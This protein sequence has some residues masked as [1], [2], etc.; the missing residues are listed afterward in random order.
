[1]DAKLQ[2]K[3]QINDLFRQ[4]EAK[5]RR[6]LRRHKGKTI[7]NRF[8]LTDVVQEVNTQ[9]LVAAETDTSISHFLDTAWL[10]KVASGHFCKLQRLH[11]AQ[12]RSVAKEEHQDLNSIG[13]DSSVSDQQEMDEQI[14]LMLDCLEQMDP[15]SRHAIVRKNYDEATFRQ[16]ARELNTT[17]HRARGIYNGGLKR[18]EAM[19]HQESRLA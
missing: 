2:P 15:D 9:L 18:L 4:I 12:K 10:G 7:S 19:M 1:M 8:D 16:I 11:L 13:R 5:V 14:Q 17:E 3:T 6:A